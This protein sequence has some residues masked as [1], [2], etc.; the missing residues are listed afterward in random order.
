[1]I[2][3]PI[4]TVLGHVD[5]GKTSVL[6]YVR[7]TTPAQRE[8]GQI[9]QHPTFWVQPEKIAFT[10]FLAKKILRDFLWKVGAKRPASNTNIYLGGTEAI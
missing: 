2:K 5:H 8:A 6:D 10:I 9:T 1:M 4:I 3:Q 7:H